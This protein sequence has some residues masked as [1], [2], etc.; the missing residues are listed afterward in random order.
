MCNKTQVKYNRCSRLARRKQQLNDDARHWGRPPQFLAKWVL[1]YVVCHRYEASHDTGDRKCS[2]MLSDHQTVR[3]SQTPSSAQPNT[4]V[5]WRRTPC[6]K[7]NLRRLQ[8]LSTTA[9]LR[10]RGCAT[11]FSRK[12]ASAVAYVTALRDPGWLLPFILGQ[13]MP[14]STG[15]LI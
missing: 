9:S 15:A 4:T 1:Q 5:E 3:G 8:H 13:R 7:L 10:M 14:T 6:S 2:D 11:N 12:C